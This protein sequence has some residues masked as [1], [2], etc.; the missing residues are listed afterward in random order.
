MVLDKG[1]IAQFGT[2]NEIRANQDNPYITELL[3]GYR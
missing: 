2:P 1:K 3:E